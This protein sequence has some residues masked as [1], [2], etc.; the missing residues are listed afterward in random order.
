MRVLVRAAVAVAVA[1]AL[2]SASECPGGEDGGWTFREGR[3]FVASGGKHSFD[4]CNRVYCPDRAA[5]DLLSAGTTSEATATLACWRDEATSDFLYDVGRGAESGMWAGLYQRR[6]RRADEGWDRQSAAACDSDYEDFDG[7]EPNDWFGCPE[8]CAVVDLR[9]YGNRWHDINCAHEARC[10]C[11]YPSVLATDYAPPKEWESIRECGA[12]DAFRALLWLSV[13]CLALLVVLG[14]VVWRTNRAPEPGIDAAVANPIVGLLPGSGGDARG[15]LAV[16]SQFED[17]EVVRLSRRTLQLLFGVTAVF[18]AWVVASWSV[19][20][21]YV[22]FDDDAAIGLLISFIIVG[23]SLY[24][25]HLG[26]RGVRTRNAKLCCCC[27]CTTFLIGFQIC[28]WILSAIFF[29]SL[30]FAVIEAVTFDALFAARG[31][32]S[33]LSFLVAYN[34]LYFLNHKLLVAVSGLEPAPRSGGGEVQI[35]VVAAV[36]VGV[37]EPAPKV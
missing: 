19:Y 14:V 2:D 24:A 37:V 35:P 5:R 33:N 3:C 10:V 21:A 11:E 15:Y 30:V 16:A 29:V 26:V 17:P 28:L 13:V 27:K 34:T 22:P 7:D 25:L 9:D 20:F 18:A 23:L 6:N 31:L 8:D 4:D 32:V 12:M 1:V 36:H